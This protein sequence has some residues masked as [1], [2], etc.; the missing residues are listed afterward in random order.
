M[1]CGGGEKKRKTIEGRDADNLPPSA[2]RPRKIL[3]NFRTHTP[4]RFVAR[5]VALRHE[6]IQYFRED[7]NRIVPKSL[8]DK[9]RSD[10]IIRGSGIPR[11]CPSLSLSL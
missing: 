5:V 3:Q 10:I 8:E 2:L 1:D 6:I 11:I 7:A 4:K 9:K